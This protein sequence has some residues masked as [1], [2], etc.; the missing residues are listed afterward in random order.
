LRNLATLIPEVFVDRFE[1]T[2][3]TYSFCEHRQKT[4]LSE[5]MF[6]Y[7][8]CGKEIDRDIHSTRNILQAGIRLLFWLAIVFELLKKGEGKL[9][10]T[11]PVDSGEITPVE[12]GDHL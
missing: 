9:L 2:T 10:K 4:S 6:K 8:K 1:P 5:R 3:Q 7:Q 11:L 12:S